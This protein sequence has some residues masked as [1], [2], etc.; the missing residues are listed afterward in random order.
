LTG[1]IH[2]NKQTNQTAFAKKKKKK[3]HTH[4]F[5]NTA[6]ECYFG[7]QPQ[8]HRSAAGPRPLTVNQPVV[9]LFFYLSLHYNNDKRVI[10]GVLR[11]VIAVPSQR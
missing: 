3:K 11:A 5:A 4:H 2:P 8:G 10:L 1:F 7:Q 6:G 9:R